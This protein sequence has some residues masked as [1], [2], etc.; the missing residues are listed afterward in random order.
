MENCLKVV[1][2]C[3]ELMMEGLW[4]DVAKLRWMGRRVR[5]SWVSAGRSASEGGFFGGGGEGDF[6]RMCGTVITRF[7]GHSHRHGT[8]ARSIHP[9][10]STPSPLNPREL[11]CGSI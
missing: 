6:E 1:Q 8:L 5:Q 9:R 4:Q 10:F 2:G 3:R 11:P 7:R